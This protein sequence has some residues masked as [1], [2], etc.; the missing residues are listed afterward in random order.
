MQTQEIRNKFVEYFKQHGHQALPSSSLVPKDDPTLLFTNAGMVQFK[1]DFLGMRTHNYPCAVTVQ[2]CMRAGG[3]HND[4]DNVG[5]TKRHHTFFEML[6]NFSFGDYF[7]REAIKYAWEFLTSKDW[8]ALPPEKL[9]ITV[10]KDDKDAE[11]IWLEEIKIDP[12]RFSRCGDKD[13]FWA[14]GDTGPCGYCSEIYYD[15]GPNFQGD[16]PGDNAVEGDRYIEIWNLVFMEF[17]RD[18]EGKLKK[19]PRPSIDTGMGLERI[20]AVKQ[21]KVTHGDNYKIDTFQ[22]LVDFMETDMCIPHAQLYAKNG[23]LLSRTKVV[24][25]HIRAA[26]FLIADGI[27]ASN[28]GRGYVLR[29]IIR[30]AL[31][32]FYEITSA[33]IDVEAQVADAEMKAINTKCGFYALVQPVVSIMTDAYPELELPKQQQWIEENL[34]AEEKLFNETLENGMKIFEQALRD[35]KTKVVPG[36]IV[37]KLYDTYGFPP[38]LTADMARERN[39]QIDSAGF[40][41]EMERQR[42]LSQAKSKFSNYGT[43]KLQVQGETKFVG[44]ETLNVKSKIVALFNKAGSKVDSLSSGE[45]GILALDITSFYAE[46]GGQVGDVGEIY[47]D[48]VGFIVEDT[49]KQDNVYLHYGRVIKGIL[50]LNSNVNA[51]VSAITRRATMA[52]HSATHLLQAALRQVLGNHVDIMQRGSYVDAKRLRFDFTYSDSINKLQLLDV[53]H[54]VNQQIQEALPV[55]VEVLN[56]DEAKRQGATALF[57]E[58]YGEKVRVISMGDFSKELCGGTHVSNTGKIGV[59]KIL[60][61]SGVAAGIRRIEAITAVNALEWFEQSEA[62]LQQIHNLVKGGRENGVEKVQN[63]LQRVS[64]QEKELSRLKSKIIAAESADLTKD[65]IVIGDMKLLTLK[66]ENVDAKLLRQ[67]MDQL[68]DK[69]ERAVIVLASVQDGKIQQLVGV[70]KNCTDKISANDLLKYIA[71]QIGGSGGG[72]AD[73]AQGG[74]TNVAA[75]DGALKSI[76]DWVK[77]KI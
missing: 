2:R 25:D 56:I 8:M 47:N 15:Y 46:S 57:D 19:L 55:T 59:F 6:G 69:L 17:D 58:K 34:A 16:P 73:F 37:F 68:K 70:T 61:E 10:H 36:N 13:N 43:E 63:L 40:E 62:Q 77:Q 50:K 31:R 5:Y 42:Q 22:H 71:G 41:K 75:L 14:M 18:A 29:R 38:D 20:A 48:E 11:D 30:R 35:L 74:G 9:W 64:E 39:L 51:E 4:L 3:K 24:L 21:E 32:H 27:R 12:K 66:F 45:F 72:R 7:K 67:H 53:E 60:A 54:V 26:V 76:A 28:E 65:A 1:N 52:N 23:D 49:K 33:A 44:Y